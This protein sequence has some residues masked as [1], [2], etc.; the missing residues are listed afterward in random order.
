MR[1]RAQGL[2]AVY[3]TPSLRE[4]MLGGLPAAYRSRTARGA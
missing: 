2:R 1:V 3:R 4:R